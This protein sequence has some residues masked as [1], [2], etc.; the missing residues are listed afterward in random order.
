M[1]LL[2]IE[3]LKHVDEFRPDI[4]HIQHLSFG[5]AL[6][7]NKLKNIPKIAIC[8]GTEAL[9]EL[10]STFHLSLLKSVVESVNRLVFLLYS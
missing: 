6:A 8:H 4:I 10:D 9:F 5:M 3:I 2:H 1:D 7:C